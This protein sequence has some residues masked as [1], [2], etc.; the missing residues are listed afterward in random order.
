MI[1]VK[2]E[3][4]DSKARNML[5]L[6]GERNPDACE[7]VLAQAAEYVIATAQDKFLNASAADT[8]HL[9]SRTGRLSSSVRWW[10]DSK[11]SVLVGTGVQYAAVHEYGFRG[12]VLVS[13]HTR[14]QGGRPGV[15]VRAHGRNMRIP[16][17]PYLAPSIGLLWSTGT[18]ERL[19][20]RAMED[21]ARGAERDA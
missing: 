16:A 18:M 10:S 4:D 20:E 2:V 13:Q 1:G 6:L 15:L 21:N 3:Y 19:V 7:R 17:R 9:H 11:L 8:A 5:R 14:R 12:R